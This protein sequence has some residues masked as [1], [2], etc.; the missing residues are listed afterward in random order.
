MGRTKQEILKEL[1]E[2][3]DCSSPYHNP[4]Y[5][6]VWIAAGLVWLMENTK[7]K[8]PEVKPDA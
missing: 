2:I 1:I 6:M 4:N 3:R 8:A 5:T 7:D